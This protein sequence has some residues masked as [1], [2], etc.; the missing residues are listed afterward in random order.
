MADTDDATPRAIPPA[1]PATPAQTPRR[2]A[3]DR[4][5]T[6]RRECITCGDVY[7]VTLLYGSYDDGR[8]NACNEHIAEL[9]FLFC[10]ADGGLR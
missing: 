4:A 2:R 7:I 9:E 6:Q 3:S 1:I 5:I 10:D 8:C